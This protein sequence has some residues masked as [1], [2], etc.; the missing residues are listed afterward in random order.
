MKTL[1]D[2]LNEFIG[3]FADENEFYSARATVTAID[4][5]SNTCTVVTDENN[6]ELTRV[7]LSTNIG[8]KFG[9]VLIPSIDSTVIVNFNS[10]SDA[11]ISQS[12]E[13]S[14]AKIIFD[15]TENPATLISVKTA[16]IT[17]DS[18]L[19]TFNQGSNNG[20][21]KVQEMSDRLNELEAL[22]TQLQTDFSSWVTVPQDGGAALKALLTAGFGTKVIPDSK[23]VDFE[24]NKIK[25]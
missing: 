13:L 5:N 9:I 4:L 3:R 1:K 14:E 19:V 16:A 18:D 8:A 2:V 23:I 15:D 20:L 17:I 24:N 7:K 21:V 6:K 11:Y 22:F 12:S 10:I 25:Q